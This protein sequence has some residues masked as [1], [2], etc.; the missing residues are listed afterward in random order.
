MSRILRALPGVI[1]AA[2][3]AGVGCKVDVDCYKLDP[4]CGANLLLL[5]S[6]QNYPYINASPGDGAHAIFL[7]VDGR[8]RAWGLGSSG[9]LGYNNTSNVGDSAN[10]SII[11]AGDVPVGGSVVQ[12]AAGNLHSCALMAN[13]AVR[14]WGSN[15]NGQLGQ[16][17]TTS[18][19]NSA[20]TSIISAGDISLGGVATQITAGYGFSCAL[21]TTGN[22]RCWGYGNSGRLGYSAA[23]DVAVSPAT[24]ILATGDVPVGGSV[25]QISAGLGHTCALLTT[26]AVRCWGVGSSGELGY[27]NTNIVGNAPASSIINAGDV[28]VGA[29]VEQIAA[30]RL[31]TCALLTTGAVRCWGSN[32]SGQL[33]YNNTT[34]VGDS[35]ASSIINAGDVPLGGR[36][37]QVVMG[38]FHACALLT[39][40]SVRCW[41]DGAPGQLGYNSATNVGNSAASSIVNAG[42]VPLGGKAVRI[43][44]GEGFTCAI[45][46]TGGVRCWGGNGS[47]MLGYNHTANVGNSAAAS[48]IL[49][50]DVPIF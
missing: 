41:G 33:G 22:V 10:T 35:P 38:D 4:L 7:S 29:S 28:P 13:G 25:R 47:G 26:G 36:A 19:G 40:G 20:A 1:F 30:G 21:L 42:D 43:T 50:G 24:S 37:T 48:I 2:V 15:V 3:T 23:T 8:V 27:S 11:R 5:Y 34:N 16:N 14:C 49:S 17:N 31:S 45:L 32:P 44:A 18:L 9:Q 46:T 39:T 6:T 12:V